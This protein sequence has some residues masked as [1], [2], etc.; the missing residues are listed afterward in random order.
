MFSSMQVSANESCLYLMNFSTFM[1]LHGNHPSQH[2]SNAVVE[3]E[4]KA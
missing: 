3:L 1:A 4:I 2:A